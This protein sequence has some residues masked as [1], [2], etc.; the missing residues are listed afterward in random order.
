MQYSLKSLINFIFF[1]KI[2]MKSLTRFILESNSRIMYREYMK[3]VWQIKDPSIRKDVYG[4]VRGGYEA[5]KG[6][7]DDALKYRLGTERKNL[8]FLDEMIM[9]SQ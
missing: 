6:L 2:I 7:D 8:K 1:K 5:S 4:Q 9:F 3:K